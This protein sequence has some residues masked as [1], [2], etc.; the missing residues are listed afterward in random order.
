MFN[1]IVSHIFTSHLDDAGQKEGEA[2]MRF[3]MLRDFRKSKAIAELPKHDQEQQWQVKQ[4]KR[5][6]KH[7]AWLCVTWMAMQKYSR[8]LK[9]KQLSWMWINRLRKS[10]HDRVTAGSQQPSRHKEVAFIWRIQSTSI[11][12]TREPTPHTADSSSA[13]TTLHYK[14]SFCQNGLIWEGVRWSEQRKTWKEKKW[15]FVRKQEKKIKEGN[16]RNKQRTQDPWFMSC[17][18]QDPR[19]SLTTPWSAQLPAPPHPFFIPNHQVKK[20]SLPPIQKRYVRGMTKGT[21]PYVS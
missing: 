17:Q 5:E 13:S 10:R 11:T 7:R 19:P 1:T 6:R 4:S 12:I 20:M 18:T 15:Q 21:F 9:S 2:T 16:R 8:G 3:E 14:Q